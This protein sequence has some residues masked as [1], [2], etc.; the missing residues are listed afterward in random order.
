MAVD[1]T[2]PS[3]MTAE[4]T[5]ESDIRK[6]MALAEVGPVSFGQ[7]VDTL[8]E[9][10]GVSLLVI[11]SFAFLVVPVPGVS[12]A[13]SVVFLLLAMTTLLGRRTY[14]PEFAT[15]RMIPQRYAIRMFSAAAW[16]TG[17]AGRHVRPRWT[18]LV[19]GGFRWLVGVSLLA[20]IV[21]F[22]LPI[23]IPFNNSP[24][25]FCMLLLGLGLW[26]RDGVMVLLGH[27]SNLILW[28]ILVMAG[29]FLFDLG[30]Q[31]AAWWA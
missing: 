12:T 11:L 14:L 25:A 7:L 2:T 16:G 3:E 18:V 13:A 19:R 10:A 4:H 31:A 1:P 22:A 28:V 26:A 9:R 30:R 21:A 5:L 15:R 20:A 17:W 27:L 29:Q 23:P 8:Q 6:L 24:P